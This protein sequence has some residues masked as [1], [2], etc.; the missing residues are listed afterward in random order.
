MMVLY[1]EVIRI[2]IFFYIYLIIETCN[3]ICWCLNFPSPQRKFKRRG[4]NIELKEHGKGKSRKVIINLHFIS[5]QVFA[6]AECVSSL[7]PA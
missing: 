2:L 1:Y 3:E 5:P 7:L 4:C 6:V